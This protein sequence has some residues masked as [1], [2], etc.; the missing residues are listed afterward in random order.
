MLAYIFTIKSQNLMMLICDKINLILHQN[1]FDYNLK[2][3]LFLLLF[4][5]KYL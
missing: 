5:F 1:T 2:Y 4:D 3:L